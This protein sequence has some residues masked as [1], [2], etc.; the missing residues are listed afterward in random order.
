MQER[1]DH[2][3]EVVGNCIGQQNHRFFVL[4]LFSGI[5]TLAA[6]NQFRIS[7][8]RLMRILHT[9]PRRKQSVENLKTRLTVPE[10]FIAIRS[11]RNLTLA[12]LY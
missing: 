11:F 12:V 9:R 1:F 10:D 5:P 7:L 6:H 3:C 4:F 2:H 8:Q